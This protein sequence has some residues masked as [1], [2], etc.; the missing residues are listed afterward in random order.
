MTQV[1][2]PGTAM[3]P[4][5]QL[6]VSVVSSRH[7]SVG[8]NSARWLAPAS[9]LSGI[10]GDPHVGELVTVEGYVAAVADQGK[11]RG[12]AEHDVGLKVR[13]A[14]CRRGGNDGAEQVA[15]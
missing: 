1:S 12:V 15:S 3:A 2:S 7:R 5:N 4:R 10:D 13:H 9:R 8:P 11:H 14:T 6:A